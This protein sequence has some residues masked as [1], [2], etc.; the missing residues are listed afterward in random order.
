MHHAG[1]VIAHAH[2]LSEGLREHA[3]VVFPAESSAEK[4]GTVVHPD[5]RL[6]RLRAAIGHPGDVRATWSVIAELAKHCGH[7][8]SVLTSAMAFKQLMNAV[9]FYEGITLEQIG[10][11]GV[12]WPAREQA[13]TFPQPP[14]GV[15]TAAADAT[16]LRDGQLRLG[17][18]RPIW[19]SSEVEISPALKFLAA[20][21]Q[22]ELA[23]EDASRL[24]VAY[25]DE[26]FVGS[27]GTRI[28]ATVAVRTGVPA[29]TAF[30]A[31]GLAE[32]SAN[33]ITGSTIE[34]TRG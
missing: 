15:L 22:L 12:R 10:G 26:V 14:E 32:Q 3:T 19:A 24:G 11:H 7:D 23:P 17:R 27:N 29:G 18:Y 34:V 16:P 8:L 20:S 1:I 30:L 33:E 31:D 9:P 2:V 4:E 6:Q 5:G 21:Q 13:S 25:G 28:R